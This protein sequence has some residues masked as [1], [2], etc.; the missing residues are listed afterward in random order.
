MRHLVPTNPDAY[1]NLASAYLSSGQAKEAAIALLE[2]VI[3]DG[4]RQEV[5][6]PLADIYRKLDRGG[7]AIITTEGQPR[8]NAECAIVHDHVCAAFTDLRR[9]LL[10]AKQFDLARRITQ[11]AVQLYHCSPE[12]VQPD[13]PNQL[14]PTHTTS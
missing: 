11:N 10:D 7:C 9:T 5:I 8:I 4:N 2:T 14:N 6:Q 13:N 12:G 1:L 3:I